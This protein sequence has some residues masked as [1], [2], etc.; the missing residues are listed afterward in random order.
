MHQFYLLASSEIGKPCKRDSPPRFLHANVSGKDASEQLALATQTA[1]MGFIFSLSFFLHISSFINIPATTCDPADLSKDPSV[2]T[3]REE[4]PSVFM[5]MK[6]VGPSLG[7]S[8]T[9]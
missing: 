3:G 6:P 1:D 4:A 2:H 9:C 7:F 8:Y 5:N